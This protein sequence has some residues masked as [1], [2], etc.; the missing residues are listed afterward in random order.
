MTLPL[1]LPVTA[2]PC[3]SCEPPCT[4]A[5]NVRLRR[6][7][8]CVTQSS[9]SNGCPISCTGLLTHAPVLPGSPLWVWL[10]KWG[11]TTAV[12]CNLWQIDHLQPSHQMAYPHKPIS[13]AYGPQRNHL[14]PQQQG[15]VQQ[16][17]LGL[18]ESWVPIYAHVMTLLLPFGTHCHTLENLLWHLA[19]WQQEAYSLCM[20]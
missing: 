7:F 9:Y 19:N 11:Y 5:S 4:P 17:V 12:H 13:K 15:N 6:G 3:S 16:Q 1:W 18:I 2:W 14:K 20:L 8:N 10:S